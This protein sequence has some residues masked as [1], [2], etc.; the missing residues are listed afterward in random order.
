MLTIPVAVEHV[1]KKK[2][3]LESALIEGIVNLSAAFMKNKGSEV[4]ALWARR[5]TTVP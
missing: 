3:F 2:P 4:E 5:S 1:I